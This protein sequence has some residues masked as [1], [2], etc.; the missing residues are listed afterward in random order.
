MTRPRHLRF[1]RL[2]FHGSTGRHWNATGGILHAVLGRLQGL[3]RSWSRRR[4]RF[5]RPVVGQTVEPWL[6]AHRRVDVR[7]RRR[8]S[9]PSFTPMR[10]G[11]RGAQSKQISKEKS[12]CAIQFDMNSKG[13]R[14]RCGDEGEV[15]PGSCST[16]APCLFA[17]LTRHWAHISSPSTRN[18][19]NNPGDGIS[20]LP[21]H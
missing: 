13:W 20:L 15:G 16:G 7:H 12:K 18:S 17:L 9:R 21:Y 1:W 5:G 8:A 10:T 3:G 11:Q 2:L 6:V 19:T 14:N 4:C